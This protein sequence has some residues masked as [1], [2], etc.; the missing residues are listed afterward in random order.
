MEMQL[1]QHYN[2]YNESSW[3]ARLSNYERNI[4]PLV[5]RV[6]PALRQQFVTRSD[7]TA[8]MA[9][10]QYA[11]FKELLKRTA[12]KSELTVER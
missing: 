7:E 6:L 4:Q 3:L 9:L 10:N 1:F 11:Q 2:P 5:K 12:V 8:E